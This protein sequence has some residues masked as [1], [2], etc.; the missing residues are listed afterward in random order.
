[1]NKRAERMISVD[2]I[3]E[4]VAVI[5]ASSARRCPT[6]IVMRPQLAPRFEQSVT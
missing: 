2:D 5:L 3:A 1:M 6:A 4:T